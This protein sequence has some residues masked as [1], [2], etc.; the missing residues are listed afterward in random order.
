[1]GAA[2]V[3]DDLTIS[4]PSILGI[5]GTH[6]VRDMF[7]TTDWCYDYSYS[8]TPDR[9]QQANADQTVMI[10]GHGSAS[11]PLTPETGDRAD[12][13]NVRAPSKF[14]AQNLKA[15]KNFNPDT[16]QTWDD[17]VT[18]YTRYI[19]SVNGYISDGTY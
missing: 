7:K 2:S 16:V 15:F 3:D 4:I 6:K 14:S 17:I 18:D 10:P 1:M 9:G 8:V 19:N 13:F 5:Y 11:N 12:A